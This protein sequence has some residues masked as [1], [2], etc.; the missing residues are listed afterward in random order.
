MTVTLAGALMGWVYACG[1]RSMVR[2]VAIH[3]SPAGQ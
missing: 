3:V 2:L 1:V